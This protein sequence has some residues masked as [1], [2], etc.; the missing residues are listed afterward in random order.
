MDPNGIYTCDFEECKYANRELI[1]FYFNSPRFF[2]NVNFIKDA[3]TLLILLSADFDIT[4]ISFGYIPNITLK[5]KW[6]SKHIPFCKFIGIDIEQ[7]NDKSHID[8]NNAIF[9]DDMQKYL[10]TSNAKYKILF[11]ETPFYENRDIKYDRCINW[12]ELYQYIMSLYRIELR[13]RDGYYL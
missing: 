1:D 2:E 9:V 4:I 10:D 5:R 12:I 11:G 7:Y 8:M 6:I 3:E 13:K